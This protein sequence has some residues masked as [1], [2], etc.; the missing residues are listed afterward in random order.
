MERVGCE[1]SPCP[2]LSPTPLLCPS[3]SLP[4]P[5]KK[6]DS[7]DEPQTPFTHQSDMWAAGVVILEMYAGGLAGLKA[8][9]GDNALELLETCARHSADATTP[10]EESGRV[11]TPQRRDHEQ[12]DGDGGQPRAAGGVGNVSLRRSS[13]TEKR[14]T[15]RVDMP[16]GVIAVLR[17]IF[18]REAG[19]RPESM[20]VRGVLT[21]VAVS[22][23]NIFEIYCF[24]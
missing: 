16:E 8:V 7:V 21:E 18:Q 9:R 13:G 14:C 17:D 2:R 1:A 23:A 11:L 12:R 24:V 15:F 22:F 5:S 4:Q 3:S 20:T 19:D 6:H 10:V